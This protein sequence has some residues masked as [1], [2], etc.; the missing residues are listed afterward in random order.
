M[1]ACPYSTVGPPR[2]VPGTRALPRPTVLGGETGQFANPAR[3]VLYAPERGPDVE[4][5]PVLVHGAVLPRIPSHVPLVRVDRFLRMRL[6][7]S[8]RAEW[9][10]VAQAPRRLVEPSGLRQATSLAGAL[11]QPE[12]LAIT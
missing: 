4:Q 9:A 6:S 10:W 11:A 3:R 7:V 5:R 2:D 1:T 12:H 8:P